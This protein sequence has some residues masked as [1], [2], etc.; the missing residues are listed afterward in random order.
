[1]EPTLE[2][3][4]W[5][6]ERSESKQEIENDDQAINQNITMK[7][8]RP[9]CC[10]DLEATEPDPAAAAI[11]QFA[12]IKTNHDNRRDA[13]TMKCRPWKDVS[14]GAS[15][16][17][18]VKTSDFANEKPFWDYAAEIHK[19]V[20]G[21]DLVGFN[22][23][24]YDIPLLWE[25]FY[26]CGIR[27][28]LDGIN[29]IDCG[30]LF[31]IREP[32]DLTAAVQFYCG[33]VHEGAHDALADVD[34]TLQVLHGQRERYSDIA[35]MGVA[36]MSEASKYDGERRV[37]LAGK[38]VLDKDGD[39]V[40]NFGK[41]KGVKLKEDQ[42]LAHWLLSRDFSAQTKMVVSNILDELSGP[43]NPDNVF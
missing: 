12:A 41:S 38:I 40:Y 15:K 21:C 4:D 2:H 24:N 23:S 7:L 5:M 37:D 34:A 39:P 1:M 26:R 33:K 3:L 25:E 16:V 43:P 30:T 42:G 17:T 14:E 36:E 29:V 35:S 20:D 18:G 10:F 22:L 11:F 6:H 19:F 9:L 32:R 31:N 13:L 8:I 28:N 27:W